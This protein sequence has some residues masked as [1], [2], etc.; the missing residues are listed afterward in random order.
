[1]LIVGGLAAFISML[2]AGVIK[3]LFAII[4]G[5]RTPAAA[6]GDAAVKLAPK[7]AS[8]EPGKAV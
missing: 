6:A 5:Q 2:V 8:S 3:L 1:M 7:P 4:R